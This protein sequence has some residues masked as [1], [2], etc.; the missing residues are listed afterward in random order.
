MSLQYDADFYKAIEP[1][2]PLL[3][4]APQFPPHDVASRRAYSG[5]AFEGILAALEGISD[6]NIEETKH[7]ARAND[8]YHI[9]I[10]RFKSKNSDSGPNP[11][12]LHV[13][14]GGMIMGSVKMFSNL[15]KQYV[16]RTTV[17]IFSVEYRLAPE[18]PHPTPGEDCYAALVW[19]QE[20]ANEFNIDPS[21]IAIYGESGGGGIAAGVALMARDRNLFPKLAKQILIYPML[22]DRTT[23]PMELVEPFTIWKIVDNITGWSA[24][25]GD[26]I[27]TDG[28]SPYAAPARVESVEGLPPTYVD[29]GELD[30]F[31]DED[32]R[33][34]S[35]IAAANISTEFHLYPGVPHGWDGLVRDIPV[36]KQ[37][38][39]NRA[40]AM[41]SF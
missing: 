29:V 10:F 32:I 12:I 2:L 15:L 26:N 27:G 7:T 16:S 21:R 8:D 40:R 5:K 3:T 19:L 14:G 13:H 20:H 37:A 33:Y 17:Q 1:M 11:A 18:Y 30:I 36:S 41:L 4:A 35:R 38:F 39:E 23:K 31:R 34:A 6:N 24:M 28:V 22:D 25:L 9:P